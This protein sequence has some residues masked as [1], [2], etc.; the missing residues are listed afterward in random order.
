MEIIDCE[1]G[2][3]E[4]A[5]LRSGKVTASRFKD[6]MAKGKGSKPSLTRQS[7]LYQLAAEILTTEPQDTYTNEA[8]VHGTETEPFARA[9]YE[10]VNNVEVKQVGFVIHN[11]WIGVSPDGL[12]SKKGL[13]EVKCPNSSTQIKRYLEGI[14]PPEYKAQVMGQLWVTE[15]EWC[16]FVSYDPR[17][18][19]G[20][21]YF[22]V[23]VYRDDKYITELKEGIY[24]FVDELQGLLEK[25]R[26]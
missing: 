23:R 8:M 4:W 24:I 11:E 19:A 15:R 2:T 16:D 12:L 18:N 6:V 20:S 10:H 5:L 21:A 14:F 25:L 17:I 22:C 13:I 3:P 7:Y 26:E 1:Q 9:Y